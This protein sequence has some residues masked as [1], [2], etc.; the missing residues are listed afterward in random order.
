[1]R[2]KP[3]DFIVE[4]VADIYEDHKISE[5]G[6]DPIQLCKDMGHIVLPYS[7]FNKDSDDYNSLL[8]RKQDKDGFSW[9]N[10]KTRKCEIYYND[11]I[12][13]RLRI[14]F[15]IPHEL[16]HV[17]Y[18][19]IFQKVITNEMEDVANEF[20]RQLYAP[21]IILVTYDIMTVHEIMSTF[22]VTEAFAS[23]ILNRL[24]N[25]LMFHGKE[26]SENEHRVLEIFDYNR[27]HKK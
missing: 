11:N 3:E 13:P 16:G 25:R 23:T 2:Y 7:S 24:Q 4:L 8:L 20:A 21:H 18:G 17:E 26:F 9:F 15:T 27:R 12:K 6:F 22:D 1:M 14:K 5:F 19:H 10:P